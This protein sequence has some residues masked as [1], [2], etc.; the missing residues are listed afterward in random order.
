M[1]IIFFLKNSFKMNNLEKKIFRYTKH[2]DLTQLKPILD[3]LSNINLIDKDG[4]TLLHIASIY[5]WEELVDLLIY[6]G[7]NI[8]AEDDQGAM[9]VEYAALNGHIGI[10]KKLLSHGSNLFYNRN[11]FSLLHSAASGGQ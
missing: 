4:K 3:K 8:G 9:A 7:I 11:S 10:L 2:G 6:R 1:I 5:G